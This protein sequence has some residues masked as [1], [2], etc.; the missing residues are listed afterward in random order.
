VRFSALPIQIV[1]AHLPGLL[2]AFG[3]WLSALNFWL[4]ALRAAC[5]LQRAA[6]I[7]TSVQ[8]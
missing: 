7:S 6:F 2:S 4:S 8:K 3:F 5:G 1:Y